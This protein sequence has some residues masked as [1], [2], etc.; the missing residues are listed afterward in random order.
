MM[1]W[2]IWE[3]KRIFVLL[4]SGQKYTGIVLEVVYI[5]DINSKNVYLIS[6]KDKYN[7]LASFSTREIAEI[8]ED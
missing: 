2:K 7:K 4:N 6:I 1:E 3:G 5:G 8:R